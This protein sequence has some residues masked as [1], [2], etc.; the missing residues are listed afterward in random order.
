MKREPG[1][2]DQGVKERADGKGERERVPVAFVPE[3]Y[4]ELLLS[5]LCGTAVYTYDT[6]GPTRTIAEPLRDFFSRG[7]KGLRARLFNLILD[8]FDAPERDYQDLM[9]V[10]EM[11]HSGTLIIDDIEDGSTHR[12]GK[13]CIHQLYGTDVAMNA[14]NALYFLSLLPLIEKR[15]LLNETMRSRLFEIYTR[16][17]I[18]LH[19]GQSM[20][21]AWRRGLTKLEDIT[22]GKYLEMC[23][24]KTGS[25]Y[26][27]SAEMAG[28]LANCSEGSREALGRFGSAIGTAFQIQDDL[29]DLQSG[30]FAKAK[31]CMGKDIT[32]GKI[33][34]MV[35]HALRCAEDKDRERLKSI[36]ALN[37]EDP[38][39]IREAISIM[40][41]SGSLAYASCRASQIL[42]EACVHL[43]RVLPNGSA[44]RKVRVF[45]ESFVRRKL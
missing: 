20:D 36:L 31:G 35:I 34:L 1:R 43:F 30:P 16:C 33:T 4:D 41:A 3:M 38:V 24:L 40:R 28:V 39:L 44:V 9:W 18:N 26:R 27:M 22:E 23:R 32:E 7:G 13:P 25:L 29:L 8:V 2:S 11:S 45:A 42:D 12:R 14:G 15:G 37:T 10:V 6:I 5:E 19:F 21:I 17:M